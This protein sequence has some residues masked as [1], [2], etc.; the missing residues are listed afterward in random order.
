LDEG[1]SVDTLNK[2]PSPDLI[3][4]F[5]FEQERWKNIDNGEILF[6]K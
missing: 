3:S 1:E 4:S 2:R 6:K 5:N